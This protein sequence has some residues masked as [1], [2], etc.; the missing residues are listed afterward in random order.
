MCT[1]Q[2]P[3][4]PPQHHDW[5]SPTGWLNRVQTGPTVQGSGLCKASVHL[6]RGSVSCS[7]SSFFSFFLPA[8]MTH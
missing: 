7:S 6:H 5:P 2:S 4:P 8:S 3:P 1:N